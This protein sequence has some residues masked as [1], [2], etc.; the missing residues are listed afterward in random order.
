MK[1]HIKELKNEGFDINIVEDLSIHS[2][3]KVK[4]VPVTIV[5]KNGKEIKRHVGYLSKSDLKDFITA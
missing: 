2:Q 3:Y 5:L 1:P 4:A